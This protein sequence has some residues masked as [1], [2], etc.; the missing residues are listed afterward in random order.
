MTPSK[1]VEMYGSIAAAAR[2]LGIP[3]T[4]FQRMLGK[5]Y[6]SKPKS[7]EPLTAERLRS[8]LSYDPVTG[9]FRWI[10]SCGKRR[11]GAVAGCV[12]VHGYV[13]IRID[14]QL[15]R[16]SRLAWLH[17]RGEWPADE[18]DHKSRERKDDRFENLRAATASQ[19]M[20]N[21]T[22]RGSASGARGVWID[23]SRKN[24]KF[25]AKICVNRRQIHLG[26]FATLEA[27]SHAYEAA[28]R[29]Y[30]G[31]FAFSEAKQ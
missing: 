7:S 26:K 23:H 12:C 25:C 16:S 28:A 27:A 20:A 8:L 19:N 10:K 30:F 14:G 21:R 24:K 17:E 29:Q 15:Y 11:A 2:A 9:E 22:S 18:I 1:A 13:V 31:D 3:Q 5:V 6:S 4:T